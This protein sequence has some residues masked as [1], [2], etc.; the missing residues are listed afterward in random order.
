MESLKND[1]RVSRLVLYAL[2]AELFLILLQIAYMAIYETSNPGA[3]LSFDTSYME[4]V[5]FFIFQIVGFFVFII[6]ALYINNG[7]FERWFGK[8]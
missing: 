7:D 5:G 3:N 6:I 8:P 2:L 4:H 1:I